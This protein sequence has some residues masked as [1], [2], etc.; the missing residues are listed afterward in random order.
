[1]RT[2]KLH[3]KTTLLSS[4]LTVA[5]LIAAL[6]VT[7]AAIANIERTD[8]ERLAEIQAHDLAQHISDV[9][10]S[11]PETLTRAA[12]LIKGT[13]PNV[14]SVRIWELSQGD[15]VEK[16]V[17]SGSA[18]ATPIPEETKD[19]LRRGLGK[20]PASS[21]QSLYRV[22]ANIFE[23]GHPS[24]AVEI[25]QRFDS[26]GTVAFRYLKSVIWMFLVA[27]ALILVGTYFLFRQLQLT[28]K[29][30]TERGVLRERVRDATIELEERNQQLQETNLELWR[31]NRRMNELGRLA[32]AGQTAAHFAHEVGTPLNLIS[33]HVQLLKSD[34]E[35]DPRDAESRIRT[36][37]A[38]I[39]RIERIVRRMLDKTRFETELAPLDLN[40][41]LRKLCDAMSPAF[42]KRNIRLV[43][44]FTDNLPLMAG[45][46]DR[47]QQLFLNLINNSLDAMP[48]GGE[49]Q[50]R[51]G[52][53]GKS[54]KSQRILV[55]FIDTGTG[56]TPE[57]MS[58]IFDPLYT[59]KD[60]GQ[61]TGL[62]LV[63]VSQIV[64][65]HG[66]RVEVESELGQGTRFRLTFAAI[67]SDVPVVE[68]HE[69]EFEFGVR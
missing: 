15:F 27:I 47:L 1:M 33:G 42:D 7:S 51:T 35:R 58:H 53:E 6:A 57:V 44:T 46:S 41:V 60:R 5:M 45:S 17:A 8:D 20:I 36:I 49:I 62:G 56:M 38:Q 48:E 9:R 14:T 12:N 59:T 64:A 40:S 50:I 23:N 16:A 67:P 28:T 69:P 61:G 10:S 34:L 37:S 21:D 43:E 55:D 39:E 11:D 52:L 2:F 29:L 65:E 26:I 32:A 4:V 19:A 24:G 66:G 25:V 54:G 22:F 3:A 30:E 63:I 68:N 13:R 18:P 31:T